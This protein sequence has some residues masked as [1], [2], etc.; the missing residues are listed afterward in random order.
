MRP[1]TLLVSHEFPIPNIQP[2]QSFGATKHGK[3]TYVYA[4]R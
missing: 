3:I 4:M 2:T 1:K